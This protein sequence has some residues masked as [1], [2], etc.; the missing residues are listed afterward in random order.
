M[1]NCRSSPRRLRSSVSWSS[2]RRSDS[3]SSSRSRRLTRSPY[4][5]ALRRASTSSSCM[6]PKSALLAARVVHQAN[7]EVGQLPEVRRAL[8]FRG[9]AIEPLA[10]LAG[11]GGEHRQAID[12]RRR[13]RAQ[14]VLRLVHAL[15][16]RS[17][18]V[19]DLAQRALEPR[20]LPAV[21]RSR[22]ELGH[23]LE[24]PL[25]PGIV[26]QHFRDVGRQRM[27][28]PQQPAVHLAHVAVAHFER[29]AK[30]PHARHQLCDRGR[31]AQR[32]RLVGQHA[33]GLARIR[34]DAQAIGHRRGQR[35]CEQLAHF[36]PFGHRRRRLER[37]HPKRRRPPR[38]GRPRRACPR[39]RCRALR[40]DCRTAA[41]LRR[42][43]T[44]HRQRSPRH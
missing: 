15:L 33:R 1:S 12:E 20:D 19:D 3:A 44:A 39:I 23:R 41:R 4:T 11:V 14:R 21:E 43:P 42:S 32:A 25:Q 22:R 29:D 36:E 40:R 2:C 28:D 8:D 6:R 9:I 34:I 37:P 31:I 27:H 26:A 38:S 13:H 17:L 18:L 7:D 5:S 16:Q 35:Q 10:V 24:L 30:L